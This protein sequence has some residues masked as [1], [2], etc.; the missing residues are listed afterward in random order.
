[1]GIAMGILTGDRRG[2]EDSGAA[3]V[4][5][6]VQLQHLQTDLCADIGYDLSDGITACIL[7]AVRR[8]SSGERCRVH[9]LTRRVQCATATRSDPQTT[10][11]AFFAVRTL[12]LAEQIGCFVFRSTISRKHRVALTVTI[13]VQGRACVESEEEHQQKGYEAQHITT[14]R[15]ASSARSR[16]QEQQACG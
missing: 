3:V 13:A 9:M 12:G 1:M 5:E 8:P 14:A 2:E 11:M 16:R 6:Q 15:Y 7:R 10:T 4:V